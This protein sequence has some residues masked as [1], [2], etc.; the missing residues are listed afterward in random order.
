MNKNKK[1][2]FLLFLSN[3]VLFGWYLILDTMGKGDGDL[4]GILAMIII[5]GVA[6]LSP[7]AAYRLW[8]SN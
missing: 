2:A 1:T 4:A 5:M 6:I 8:N 3:T 7:I